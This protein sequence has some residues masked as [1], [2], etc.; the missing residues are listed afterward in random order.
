MRLFG[1]VIMHVLLRGSCSVV[2]LRIELS[3]PWLS[4]EVG[5]PAL[6]Y[7]LVLSSSYGS[8]THLSTLKGRNPGTD[9]PTSQISARTAG[10]EAL[11]SSSP[12]FQ[13]SATPSQLPTRIMDQ[14]RKKPDVAVTPGFERA[15]FG[16]G[17]SVN[18]AADARATYSP[19]GRRCCLSIVVRRSVVCK[20]LSFF[21]SSFQTAQL[22]VTLFLRRPTAR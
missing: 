11:E 2:A 7:H 12:G 16:L 5:Q 13:P 22:P 3:A 20:M 8:R 18:S 4:A 6:D 15:P 14:A 1:R 19:T 10:R 21:V 9:R 17:P